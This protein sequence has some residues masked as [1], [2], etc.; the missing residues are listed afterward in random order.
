MCAVIILLTLL[1]RKINPTGSLIQRLL[2][3]FVVSFSTAHAWAQDTQQPLPPIEVI[4]E[5]EES[6]T[7]EPSTPPP[8]HQCQVAL[9]NQDMEA[10]YKKLQ[11]ALEADYTN[12]LPQKIKTELLSIR[13]E[14]DALTVKLFDADLENSQEMNLIAQKTVE[15]LE[16]MIGLVPQIKQMAPMMR[17]QHL[18]PFTNLSSARAE[19]QDCLMRAAIEN[20]ETETE[21]A[22]DDGSINIYK[23]LTQELEQLNNNLYSLQTSN[24]QRFIGYRTNII[25][26]QTL[27]NENQISGAALSVKIPE[28]LNS[29]H[30][31]I[32]KMIPGLELSEGYLS[33]AH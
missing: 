19:E 25:S 10:R 30:Q 16:K 14:I 20:A 7:P 32:E 22:T 6:Q 4:E 24:V 1:T 15:A 33:L 31:E 12:G 17:D 11:N 13:S 27:Y 29:V 23:K 9:I 3:A 18:I 26:Q 8:A 28:V 5:A 21:I 2:L